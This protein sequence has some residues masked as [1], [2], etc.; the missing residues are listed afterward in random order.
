MA[1]LSSASSISPDLIFLHRAPTQ[2]EFFRCSLSKNPISLSALGGAS[3]SSLSTSRANRGSRGF[4]EPTVRDLRQYIANDLQMSDSAELLELLVANKILDPNLKL[5]VV[6][7]VLWRNH[8]V[9]NTS[10]TISSILAAGSSSFLAGSGISAMFGSSFK[11]A[12]SSGRSITAETPSSALPPMMVTYGLAGVD[13]EA[14]EDNV[15][16]P[17]SFI[18][19]CGA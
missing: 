9:E 3:A 18:G 8:L 14:T 13:G 11:R 12:G 17:R 16:E 15:S 1:T 5:R 2:E 7:Q 10:A 6:H 19:D 4:H